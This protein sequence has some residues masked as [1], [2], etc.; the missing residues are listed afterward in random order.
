FAKADDLSDAMQ[1]RGYEPYSKRTK[2]RHLKF[3]LIDTF[4]L[5]FMIALG[6]FFVVNSIIGREYLPDF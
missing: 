4:V 1:T 3:G 6:I 5:L 2:Y